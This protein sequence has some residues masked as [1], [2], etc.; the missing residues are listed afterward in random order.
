MGGCSSQQLVRMELKQMF[1]IRPKVLEFSDP[2]FFPFAHCTLISAPQICHKS[3]LRPKGGWASLSQGQGFLPH[4][5]VFQAEDHFG[6]SHRGV[7][8]WTSFGPHRKHLC[9]SERLNSSGRCHHTSERHLSLETH[10][11]IN[12]RRRVLTVMVITDCGALASVQLEKS[13]F[14][15]VSVRRFL[16]TQM[17][18]SLERR[19]GCRI[20]NGWIYH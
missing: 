16:G 15:R 19:R 6:S 11:T 10:E 1:A 8:A 5:K 20:E 3:S 17:A 9:H 14:R 4:N 2:A 13:P 18:Q 12:W 7:C